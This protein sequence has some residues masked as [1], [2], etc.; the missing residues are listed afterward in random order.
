[1]LRTQ[2][3]VAALIAEPMRAVPEMA[4]PGFW[5]AVRRS[6]DDTGTLLIFDE[7]PTG[8]GRT[9]KM[10]AHEHETV[11]TEAVTPDIL[12]LG[13]GLGGGM[14]PVAAVIA[15]AELDVGADWAFGHYTH[16]K[17][18]LM[19]RAGLTTIEILQSE[20]LV[21]RSAELGLDALE[22]GR[23]LAERFESIGDVRGRGLLFGLELVKPDGSPNPDLAE[24]I[25]YAALR[26]GL[27]F[28]T[29][30]GSVLTFAPALTIRETDL[31]RAFD[32][33]EASFV[34]T[35]AG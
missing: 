24:S 33:L 15:R 8:L 7:I 22:R 9:G 10:F 16:E 20:G 32:I 13:K 17:N 1:V 21:E 34:E 12:V 27:S 29:T 19:A 26:R 28:K 4:A 14:I 35:L 31:H 5:Q 11:G 3:D 25:L 6:C 30:M 2:G 18:P 23:A